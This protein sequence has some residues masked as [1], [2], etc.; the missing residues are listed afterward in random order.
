ASLCNDA[1][2]AAASA[3]PSEPAGDPVE[4]ALVDLALEA[5]ADP[6]ALAVAHPRI[7]EI[8]FDADRKR[9]VTVHATPAGDVLVL[10]K[11]APEVIA[12][13]AE[14]DS[15][16]VVSAAR[17]WAERQAGQGRRV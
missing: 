11:G 7:A 3:R 4:A 5:G 12:A 10:V 16:T 14:R 2:P 17:A 6:A 9:M 8:P 15:P 13:L 1:W